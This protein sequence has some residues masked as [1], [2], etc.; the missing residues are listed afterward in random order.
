MKSVRLPK[1]I[2]PE[3]YKIL[4]K[5]DLKGLVFEGEETIYLKL[6][7]PAKE[8]I[9]HS[10][11]LKIW[12]VKIKFKNKNPR[13]HPMLRDAP[14]F[15]NGLENRQG[16][17]KQAKIKITNQNVKFETITLTSKHK[18]PS[19]KAELS[20]KFKGILNDKMRGFYR[21]A[22][23]HKGKK[24]HLA[25]TQFEATDA[26]R[27][28]P[29]FDEPH[30][31]AVFDV[32]V[33]VPPE[34][35]AVSNSIELDTQIVPEHGRGFKI[36][37]FAPTPKMSTYLL[38]FIVGDLEYIEGQTKARKN[39]NGK[40]VL[41]RVFTTPG[42]K[43][44]AKFA[45]ETAIKSL[46]F[47]ENY[48]NIGY[49]LPVLDLIAIPDFNSAAMENWGAVTFRESALLVDEKNSSIINKQ[50]VAIVIAHELAHMWFGNLVT[51]QW[52]THLWLNEGFASYM[53]HKC[54]DAMF[55]KW[56]IW[57]KY[58]SGRF[59]EALK[60]D[61][62]ASTHPIEIEVSHPHE[63]GEIFDSVSYAKGSA[64]LRMLAEY[65]G[66]TNFRNG[67]RYYLKKHSYKNTETEDLWQAME[68]IS[69]KPVTEIMRNWTS[70][71]GYP[72]IRVIEKPKSLLLK[73]SR[74]F[75]SQVSGKKYQNKNL[76]HIPVVVGKEKFIFKAKEQQISKPK[77]IKKI[78]TGET[79]LFRVDYPTQILEQFK[80][81]IIKKTLPV[82]DR[83][84]LVRDVFALAENGQLPT[85]QALEFSLAYKN[86]TELVV[87]EELASGLSRLRN[88]LFG[89]TNFE[90]YEKFC[91]KLYKKISNNLG[92][93]ER[94]N[95]FFEKKI[96]RSLVLNQLAQFGDKKTIQK[97]L[98]IFLS[99][100]EI[101]P[102]TRGAIYTLSAKTDKI[103]VYKR[104]MNKYIKEEMHEEKE[105]IGKALAQFQNKILL[106][107]TLKF[108]LS[109]YVRPQDAPFIILSVWQN[110]FGRHLAWQFVKKHWPQL[111][112][113][114]GAGLSLLVRIINGAG[115]F[116]LETDAKDFKQFFRKNRTQGINRAISQA[117]EKIYSN[118]AWLKRD[119]AKIKKWLEENYSK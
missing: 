43:H 1:H 63:I 110:P 112:N 51:M 44:Q 118:S 22:Y 94:Q 57:E 74:F 31:K 5:P 48:F 55:P 21:S 109:K 36:V 75:S 81:L 38:A 10:K 77:I 96:L 49:P 62:L 97:A 13:F 70:K 19:G 18:I 45:L 82:L 104:L 106:L 73:Q 79:S 54:V 92:L 103:E 90:L 26:R 35:K 40:N 108:A 34:K 76:W 41:V 89:Q 80:P 4:V 46:E 27:A 17:E 91:L 78:N 105:R 60:L 6:T 65:L 37:K 15:T 68:K 53:E 58:V 72:L 9:L 61:G 66:E 101:S 50:W 25:T 93:F 107:K 67:V 64:I 33:I 2:Q 99:K 86:E 16:Y 117:L 114:F 102:N 59:N 111:K 23:F 71:P 24:R 14:S 47:Y 30:L 84:G 69:R 12:D 88:L 7:K 39:T 8:I 87:W 28:F 32:S 100:N 52:W 116:V 42:K 85:I 119:G 3:R 113:R 95:E 20:L 56:K 115:N 98:K 29:C 11:E 83:L